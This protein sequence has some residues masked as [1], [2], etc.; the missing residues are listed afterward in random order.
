MCCRDSWGVDEESRI[1]EAQILCRIS[2]LGD[3]VL[4]VAPAL[5]LR[6]LTATPVSQDLLTGRL[7]SGVIPDGLHKIC[8][9]QVPFARSLQF[10]LS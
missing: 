1:F 7:G 2:L 4:R 9:I 10:Y 5:T 3:F 6:S 8:A